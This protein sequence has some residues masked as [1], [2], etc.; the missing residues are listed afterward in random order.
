MP[1]NKRAEDRLYNAFAITRR[2]PG[3][4]TLEYHTIQSAALQALFFRFCKKFVPNCAEAAGFDAVPA[5]SRHSQP[6]HYGVFL[7]GPAGEDRDA[8][9]QQRK[10][11]NDQQEG[12]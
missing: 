11:R 10:Q 4:L 2:W 5:L 12:R 7:R 6:L 8:R 1:Q 9:P 3:V